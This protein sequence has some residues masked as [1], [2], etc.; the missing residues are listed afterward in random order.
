MSH[1]ISILVRAD[2]GRDTIDL[3]VSGCLNPDT[4]D[5]LAQ[6]IARARALDPAAPISVDLTALEHIDP[7][8]LATLRERVEA[9]CVDRARRHLVD[10][11]FRLPDDPAPCDDG[12]ALER[13]AS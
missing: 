4:G 2:V 10:V 8:A 13:I 6:Q 1:K 9:S 7:L 3:V 11:R 12:G 5:V